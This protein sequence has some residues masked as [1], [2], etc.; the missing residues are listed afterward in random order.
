MRRWIADTAGWIACVHACMHPH[1]I[2]ASNLGQHRTTKIRKHTSN[3]RGRVNQAQAIEEAIARGLPRVEAGA[4]GEHKL[5]RGYLPNLT[6]SAHYVTHPGLAGA[7]RQ[8][9]ARE[10]AQVRCLRWPLRRGCV[11]GSCEL[12]CVRSAAAAAPTDLRR[13]DCSAAWPVSW[14]PGMQMAYTWQALTVEGSPYKQGRTVEYLVSQAGMLLRGG[15]GG[16]Q[17]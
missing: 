9:L 3:A 6:Y 7:V 1:A 16:Q 4:Q 8:F 11:V 5:Q 15:C 14:R 10:D 2:A 12:R 13:L 17:P